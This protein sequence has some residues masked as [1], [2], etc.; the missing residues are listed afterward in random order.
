MK[1][2]KNN[3]NLE[4]IIIILFILAIGFVI[5]IVS[6]NW[7]DEEVRITYFNSGYEIGHQ[8]G[9]NL[10][11]IEERNNWIERELGRA[12][13]YY[14]FSDN[15]TKIRYVCGQFATIWQSIED[16]QMCGSFGCIFKTEEMNHYYFAKSE[17]KK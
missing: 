1:K 14:E 12:N 11:R 7:N 16:Y 13:C 2:Q 15:N 3:G 9:Y 8:R 6:A 10:G 5:G 17:G 4:V